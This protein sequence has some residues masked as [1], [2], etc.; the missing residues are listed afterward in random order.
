MTN[1]LVLIVEFTLNVNASE[2]DRY[3]VVMMVVCQA[4]GAGGEETLWK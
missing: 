4:Q 1:Y 2:Q 3:I